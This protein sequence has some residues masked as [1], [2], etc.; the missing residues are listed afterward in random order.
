MTSLHILRPW[1]QFMI[2]AFCLKWEGRWNTQIR[3]YASPG[4]L[5]RCCRLLRVF[6][7]TDFVKSV[8]FGHWHFCS[9]SGQLTSRQGFLRMP[10]AESSLSL[11][12]GTPSVCRPC[13]QRPRCSLLRFV[14]CSHRASGFGR[15][16]R[17]GASRISSW[18]A[19]VP[20]M[21]TAFSIPRDRLELA[22]QS[23]LGT[24]HF[25]GFPFRFFGQAFVS[26]QLVILFR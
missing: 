23:P 7:W 20:N 10:L 17:W 8:V 3:V 14:S 26:L 2:I 11:C 5:L 19:P 22:F 24:F 1:T 12:R 6:F 18:H 15:G 21:H 13:V 25:P 16:E 4:V 9:V